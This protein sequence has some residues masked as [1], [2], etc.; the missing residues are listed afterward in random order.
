MGRV[1][2]Y[3]RVEESE[4]LWILKG[5]GLANGRMSCFPVSCLDEQ[6][7]VR[8]VVAERAGWCEDGGGGC[9]FTF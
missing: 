2:R 8:N 6:P 4:L 3:R 1:V 9:L 5:L 7:I